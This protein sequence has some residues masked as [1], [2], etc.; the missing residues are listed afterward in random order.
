[1]WDTGTKFIRK[2]KSKYWKWRNKIR[3]EIDYPMLQELIPIGT[4][5]KN[6]WMEVHDGNHTFGRQMGSYPLIV[7]VKDR[8]ETKKHYDLEIT[9]HMLR[10]VV[11]RVV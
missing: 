5:L 10:S 4:V 3:K 11:G 2:N 1:M 7:G 9:G 6:V 8:I